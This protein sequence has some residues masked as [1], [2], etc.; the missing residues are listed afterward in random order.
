MLKNSLASRRF[1]APA[2]LCFPDESVQTRSSRGSFL[3][4]GMVGILVSSII[5]TAMVQI[6]AQTRRMS[7]VSQGQLLATALAQEC[8]DHLRVVPYTLVAANTGVHYAQLSGAATQDALFPRPLLEDNSL[9]YTAGGDSTVENA[10]AS[11]FHSLNADTNQDDDTV[12]VQ[13][14]N[15]SL[16]GITGLQVTVSLKWRDSSGSVKS[17]DSSSFLTPNGLG[18]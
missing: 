7:N 2:L 8:I 18:S 13:I 16:A 6:Y 3:V 1:A 14:V 10:S 17:Y 5:A 11:A 4:E 15:S 12:K 9:D